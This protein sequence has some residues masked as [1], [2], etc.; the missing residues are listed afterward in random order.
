M[1]IGNSVALV[2]QFLIFWKWY[3]SAAKTAF[4]EDYTQPW[5]SLDDVDVI[6]DSSNSIKGNLPC[7]FL[8]DKF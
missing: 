3:G 6:D 4:W 1:K 2:L 8:V 7:E 5:M